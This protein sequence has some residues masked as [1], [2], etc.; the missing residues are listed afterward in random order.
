L[1]TFT[2]WLQTLLQGVCLLSLFVSLSKNVISKPLQYLAIC[3]KL[4]QQSRVYQWIKKMDILRD[5]D[6]N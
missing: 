5:K 2:I 3:C 4:C 6:A 1:E